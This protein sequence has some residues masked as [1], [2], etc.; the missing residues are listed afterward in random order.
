M[1]VFCFNDSNETV[2]DLIISVLFH[3]SNAFNKKSLT[4]IQMKMEELYIPTSSIEVFVFLLISFL[5][6]FSSTITV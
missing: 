1:T 3:Y 2:S 4:I 5:A 6:G